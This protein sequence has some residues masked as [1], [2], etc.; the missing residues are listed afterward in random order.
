MRVNAAK[1]LYWFFGISLFAELAML[2]LA[3]AS[4]LVLDL[5][6]IFG[7]CLSPYLA[8]AFLLSPLSKRHALPDRY[9]GAGL[10]VS[11][12]G[13]A[14]ICGAL[15]FANKNVAIEV[16]GLGYINQWLILG[17][18]AVLLLWEKRPRFARSVTKR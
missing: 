3:M 18:V 10:A 7:W 15:V 11:I 4:R 5:P 6:N 13:P 14:A 16:F 12:I 17:S 1:K 2:V 8:G 9:I